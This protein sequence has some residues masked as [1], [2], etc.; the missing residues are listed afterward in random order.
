MLSCLSACL[1]QHSCVMQFLK[2]SNHYVGHLMCILKDHIEDPAIVLEGLRVLKQALMPNQVE[3]KEWED[4]YHII[5]IQF[6]FEM[7]NEQLA[8]LMIRYKQD[9]EIVL[10]SVMCLM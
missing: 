6:P 4:P 10:Y 7:L 2:S 1:R 8:R 3:A 5:N 9:H